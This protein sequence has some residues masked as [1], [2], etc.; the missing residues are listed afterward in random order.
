MEDIKIYV[1][2][3]ENNKYYIGRTNNTERRYME[4]LNSDNKWLKTFKPI[5]ILEEVILTSNHQ[6]DNI[7]KDYMSKYGID[8][9]RGGSYTTFEL[10]EDIKIFL[11]KEINHCNNKCF[12]CGGDHYANT[13][14]TPKPKL[15]ILC[16][17]LPQNKEGQDLWLGC[18]RINK[19]KIIKKSYEEIKNEYWACPLRRRTAVLCIECNCK[20]VISAGRK[21]CFDCF[22]KSMN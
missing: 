19:N 11:T 20:L 8:N 3:L 14:N 22:K 4:H 7:T 1:L 10:S 21:N 6:E 17:L 13:C 16:N 2:K 9:V 18:W 15:C 12:K 5:R